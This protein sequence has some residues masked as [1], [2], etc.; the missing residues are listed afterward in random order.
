MEQAS[1]SLTTF[2]FT[3]AEV[4]MASTFSDLNICLIQNERALV[5]EKKLAVKVD[6]QDPQAHI[7]QLVHLEGQF[8][9]A[10]W[11]INVA[12]KQREDAQLRAA[13]ELE[14]S[15]QDQASN[16]QKPLNITGA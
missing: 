13:E 5:A 4:I 14:K 10:S 3:D 8:D 16:G 7:L 6:P 15:A 2:V 1:N 12:M 11:L 9:F